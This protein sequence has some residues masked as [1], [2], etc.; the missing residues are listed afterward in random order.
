[1]QINKL[2]IEKIQNCK[3]VAIF[4]H[5]K[6]DGDCLGSACAMYLALTKLG[7]KV[8]LYSEHEPMEN[9]KFMP[10]IENFNEIKYKEY[11]LALA[12]DC[13]DEKRMGICAETF[14]KCKYKISIDH[15]FTHDTGFA[16]LVINSQVSSTCIMLVDYIKALGVE[17]TPDIAMNLYCGIATDT[18]GFIHSNTTAWEHI[19][20]GE[21]IK[22][23]FNLELANTMLFKSKT[24]EQ[25]NLTRLAL[26]NTKFY[27]D[28]KVAI[29]Y[30]T[31]KDFVATNASNQDTM[32]IVNLVSNISTCEIGVCISEDKNNLYSVSFRSKGKTD[33]SRIA[34]VFGGGGHVKASG[35]NIF[36]NLNSV[37]EKI[38]NACKAELDI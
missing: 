4:V 19:V 2:V 15:H 20:V 14:K 9:F 32:G 7:K 34:S 30:L 11:D 21:L 10:G 27:F 17:I 36:G 5:T 13:A 22:T 31:K 16:N 6:P 37:I 8:D 29:T 35:C 28:N 33:V 3:T 23:N 26:N 38:L 1:M 12:L 18:G 25:F 24:L